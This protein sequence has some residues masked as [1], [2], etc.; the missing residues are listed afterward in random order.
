MLAPHITPGLACRASLD[1]MAWI[2]EGVTMIRKIRVYPLLLAMATITVL[3]LGAGTCVFS[4]EKKAA[5]DPA[6]QSSPEALNLYTDAANYQNNSAF[7]LALDAWAQFL[8]RFG[9]DPLAPKAQHYL[10]VCQLQLKQFAKAAESFGQVIAKYPKFEQLEEAYLNL[11]WCRYSL[12]TAGDASQY[13]LAIE[14]F[15]KLAGEYPKGKYVEQALFFEAESFYALSKRKEA[16]L[17]YGRLVTGYPESKLR[18]DALYAL[19]VT[20]EDMAE[21]AQAGKAYDM[22]L[23]GY[24]TSELLTEVRMRK[25]ETILQQGDVQQAATL[26]AE[27]AVVPGF[28]A[29]GHALMRQAFCA[30]RLDKMAE[31]AALY[32]ALTER[33]PASTDVPEAMLSAGRC[34]Y[35]AERYD[36]AATWLGKVVAAGGEPAVEAAHWLCRIHLRAKRPEQALQLSDTILPQAGASAFI[37]NVKVDRADALYETDGR[38]ADALNEYLAVYKT[39]PE[40]DVAALALYN[41]AFAALDLKQYDQALD[42]AGQFLTAFANN[43]LAPDARY[44]VAECQI[45]KK[46]YAQ[47]E[48]LYR[49]LL[50]GVAEHPEKNL[51]QIRLGLAIYL[52]KKYQAAIDTLLPIAPQLTS[53]DQKAEALYL[54]GLSHFQLNQFNDAAT[55]LQAAMAAHSAWRQADETLLYLA[56]AQHKLGQID[57]ALVTLDALLKNYPATAL[58]DQVYYHLGE[59]RYAADQY[60][61]AA[62]A[63]DQVIQKYAQSTY[64]PFALYGK[65]WASLKSGQFDVAAA[66][67]SALIDQHAQHP[68]RTDALLARGMC[69]RQ[70]Q[71]FAEAIADIDQY[72]TAS[73]QGAQRADALYERGLAEAAQGE[74]PKAVQTLTTLLAEQPEYPGADKVL[75]ELGWAYRSQRDEAAAVKAFAALAEK[76]PASPLAAEARFHVAEDYYAKKEYAEAVKSYEQAAKANNPALSEKVR[77]KLGWAYYQLQQYPQSLEQF[78]AQLASYPEGEEGKLASDA[79]FMKG[80]CLFR[81]QDYQQALPALV[82]A[83]KREASVP[84]IAVLRQLHAG[85][86]AL[87]LEKFPE[88]IGFLD[89]LIEKFPESNY[90]AEAYFER[91]RARQKLNQL[92]QAVADFK[93]AAERSRDTVGARAQFMLGEIGFQQKRFDEAIKDFQR[94]MFRYGTEQ[95]PPDLKN[96]QAKAGYEAGRCCE[97]L[98]ESAASPAERTVR[99]ADAKKFYRYVVETHPDNELATEAKKRLDALAQL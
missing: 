57:Q 70:Q 67:F 54:I 79:W 31:A 23:E 25:A 88:S 14:T 13:P 81:L 42:L 53:P 49:T 66:S 45:Q 18:C 5:E 98:I 44:I 85:Q 27:V 72:L 7:E 15:E 17:A 84:Q 2:G 40:H 41:A 91:G 99:I 97:V 28:D 21:W 82:E 64:L 38:R 36:E 87:Q 93:Q 12:A 60:A 35:R 16:A 26:F 77:Y 33:F 46:D 68:L 86:A 69:Y 75:Y 8:E 9:N 24:A 11:G 37:A 61:E 47:A 29:A 30:T 48:T 32:A 51:W 52:Q 19:G 74:F 96:W 94:V 4:Q 63:Y 56:R 50:E 90:L 78:Q 34:Y 65:G 3:E 1:K 10:G 59:Y 55:Q 80:E 22:F 43:S 76:Y 89:A 6:A 71:K 73:P 95:V 58:A 62:A 39:Y 92:D 20:L 83:M